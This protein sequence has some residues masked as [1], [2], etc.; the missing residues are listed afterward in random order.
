MCFNKRCFFPVSEALT[1][2]TS[3][4]CIDTCFMDIVQAKERL[5]LLVDLS[6]SSGLFPEAYWIS[7]VTKEECIVDGGEVTVYRGHHLGH[8]VAVRE[9]RASGSAT[10][11]YCETERQM[12]VQFDS[13][14]SS[15]S[16]YEIFG[17][18]S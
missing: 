4:Q 2:D 14:P 3:A 16:N 13:L 5:Q 1:L 9:H 6:S 7:D 8:V 18:S 11:Q 17:P 15:Q 12:K 10:R